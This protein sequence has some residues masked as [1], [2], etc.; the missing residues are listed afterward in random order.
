MVC[1]VGVIFVRDKCADY[2]HIIYM[3]I[4]LMLYMSFGVIILEY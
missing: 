1:G 4:I 3:D 2:N